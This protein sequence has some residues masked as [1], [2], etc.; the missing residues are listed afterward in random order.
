MG[1]S[2]KLDDS[3]LAFWRRFSLLLRGSGVLVLYGGL[4]HFSWVLVAGI[5]LYLTGCS[6]FRGFWLSTTS[7]WVG[8]PFVWE[9]FPASDEGSGIGPSI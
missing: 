3:H 2:L 8:I 7:E 4:L 5:A 6:A 9:P 1:L